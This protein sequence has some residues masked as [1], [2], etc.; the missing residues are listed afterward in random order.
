MFR[1]Q[2]VF[3]KHLKKL[4]NMTHAEEKWQAMVTDSEGTLMLELAGKDFKADTRTAQG[5]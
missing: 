2:S 5:Y 3:A 1:I 4:E